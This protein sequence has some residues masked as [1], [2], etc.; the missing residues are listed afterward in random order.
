[1]IETYIPVRMLRYESYSLLIVPKRHTAMYRER[2]FRA[3][4][5]RLWNELTDHIKL[6]ASKDI[7]CKVLKTH[8]FD[9]QFI[10]YEM[11]LIYMSSEYVLI[12][13]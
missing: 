11:Y 2:S 7:F 4:G 13:F 9:N 10:M 12:V 1:M 8:L 5:P 3:S 6:T